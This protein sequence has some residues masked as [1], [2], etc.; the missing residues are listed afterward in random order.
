MSK[1]QK[2]QLK[3]TVIEFLAS[4]MIGLAIAVFYAQWI[5]R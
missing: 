4:G 5:L 1:K 2:N 3:K